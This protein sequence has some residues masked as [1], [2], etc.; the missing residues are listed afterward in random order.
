MENNETTAEA[1]NRETFEEAC[2]EV[3]IEAA[4][5]LIN[6][7]HINQVHLFYRGQL[8]AP[9]FAAG[10]ESLETGL[11]AEEAIPW[12]ELAF[13]SVSLCLKHFFEDRFRGNFGFHTADLAPQ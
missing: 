3:I 7:A 5:A 1:A 2:A 11:F 10:D 6:I 9:K 4:F 8:L 12:D 13:H